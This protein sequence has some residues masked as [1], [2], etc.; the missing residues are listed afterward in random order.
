MTTPHDPDPT[1]QVPT[2]IAPATPDAPAATPAAPATPAAAGTATPVWTATPPAAATPDTPVAAPAVTVPTQPVVVSAAPRRSRSGTILNVVLAAALAV[3]VGGVAFAVGRSTA[4]A[5]AAAANGG[6]VTNGTGQF[7]GPRGSFAP[8]QGGPVF[9]RGG[10]G[11]GPTVTGTV[12]AVDATGVTIKT[13]DGT[14]V[15]VATDG[16]TTYQKATA[17]T[18]GDVTVGATVDVRVDGGVFRNGNGNG[19]QGNG[20]GNGG[21]TRDLTASS[22]TVHE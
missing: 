2:P 18:A 10:L 16:S 19:N 9:S 6:L 12:T 14:E 20:N 21:T 13:A 1:T 7:G 22:I 8:G 4:P 11:G 17:G 15:K 3:A 5:S